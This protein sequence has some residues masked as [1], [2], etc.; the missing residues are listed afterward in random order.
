MCFFFRFPRRRQESTGRAT[1]V[2]DLTE[3]DDGRSKVKK[4][5]QSSW[6]LIGW[7]V[8]VQC[9]VFFQMW[10]CTV[11][12]LF[13]YCFPWGKALGNCN[14]RSVSPGFSLILM[15]SWLTFPQEAMEWVFYYR[16]IQPYNLPKR[17]VFAILKILWVSFGEKHLLHLNAWISQ[18]YLKQA[19]VHSLTGYHHNFFMILEIRKKT[20]ETVRNYKITF[21]I[22][23][24]MNKCISF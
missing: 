6:K 1:V 9:H 19:T 14:L 11:I 8:Y 20:W 13:H 18:R 15:G 12:H 7:I 24:S 17:K 2:V 21:S 10:L 23:V 4:V 3:S 16:S 22:N 5:I